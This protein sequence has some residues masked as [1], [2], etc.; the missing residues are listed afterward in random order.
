MNA[1][2][3][4]REIDKAIKHLMTFAHTNEEWASRLD[5]IHHELF[6][7]VVERLE[8]S[9]EDAEEFFFSD[10]LSHMT[11][12]FIFEE[13]ATTLWDNEDLSLISC[14]LKQRG[15]RDAPIG[16]RYLKALDQSDLKLW[17]VVAVKSGVSIDVRPY[18]TKEKSIRVKE[19]LGSKGV[20][21]W[22][23]LA[24]RVLKLD[25]TNMFSG[26][27]L[28]FSSVEAQHVQESLTISAD[29]ALSML[30]QLVDEGGLD[31]LPEDMDAF[32]RESKNE[33]LPSTLFQTWALNTYSQASAPL[34]QMMNMDDEPIEP[35]QLHFPILGRSSDIVKMLDA[36]PLLESDGD[37][38]HWIWMPD[39]ETRA[40]QGERFSIL[41]HI[42]LSDTKLILSVN[43]TARA[44][45]G[46]KLLSTL[47]SGLVGNPLT[48]HENLAQMLTEHK[49]N[50]HKL[51]KHKP[52]DLNA[53]MPPEVED[54]I[55]MHMRQHYM[56]TL[57]EPVPM[58]NDKT[59]RECAADPELKHE[60]VQW[61]KYLE[62]A[63]DPSGSAS[64]NLDWMW[65]ELNLTR[66]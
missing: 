65:D 15:W 16:Q 33:V 19:K 6:L 34:P 62:N 9:Q 36:S 40:S 13:C 49:L 8:L 29:S 25:D 54:A 44:D 42:E 56:Q 66:E 61:L 58:L 18:G 38:I 12:G 7:P 41:G 60:A 23:G 32:M 59:P 17:E 21:Q 50:E 22:D 48:V 47:L 46:G 57:D 27:M 43:S 20:S 64:P 14:Y 55:N 51:N 10:Y 39:E 24:A 63:N 5:S 28:P 35:A 53:E 2:K 11:I 52:D 26:A 4:R 30:Q 31:E 3:K 45:R 1:R 37:D